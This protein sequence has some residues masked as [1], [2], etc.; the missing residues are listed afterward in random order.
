MHLRNIIIGVAIGAVTLLLVTNEEQ[1][2]GS[3]LAVISTPA[4]VAGQRELLPRVTKVSY[5]AAEIKQVVEP[6]L[7]DRLIKSEPTGLA[8]GS[9]STFN[10]QV[11]PEASVNGSQ[12]SAFPSAQPAG[13]VPAEP[14]PEFAFPEIPGRLKE[15]LK[16]STA[17]A[18]VVIPTREELDRF[19]HLFLL[20]L[21]Q[22]SS[23]DEL[24]ANWSTM[25]WN[26]ERWV[27]GGTRFVA[28]CE[29][30][31]QRFG[32]GIYVI[33]LGSSSRIVLQAPHRYY[34]TQTGLLTRKLFNENDVL[35]ASWN[36][37]HRNQIDLAH[38]SDQFINAMTRALIRFDA[39][40]VVAQVHGFDDEK[41]ET[42][43][44]SASMIVSDTTFY[45]GRLVRRFAAEQ[46]D[47]FGFQAVRLYP[48]EVAELGGT[49]NEQVR[50]FHDMGRSGFLHIELSRQLREKLTADASVRAQ[51]FSALTSATANW[52]E[53]R[54]R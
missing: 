13:R 46:K 51:F 35:A 16:E 15:L 10:Q 32:R 4:V 43:A 47:V 24:S 28:I 29:R 7:V 31:D 9:E 38:R 40:I 50:V 44:S 53:S 42:A 14:V 30:G 19:E 18:R 37:V 39:D 33:R 2:P 11:R 22:Q 48:T 45:P 23:W 27:S 54:S 3:D 49:L 8:A 25:G 21:E 12:K 52:Q 26:L 1:Q 5:E 41:R 36:T 6:V 20:T 17:D 34:D